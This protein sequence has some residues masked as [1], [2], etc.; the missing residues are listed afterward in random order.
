V[1]DERLRGT[2]ILGVLRDG[3]CALAGDGQVTLGSTVPSDLIPE[4]QGRFP[5]RVELDPLGRDELRRILVEPESSLIRQYTALMETEGVALEFTGGALD[6]IAAIA[7]DVNERAENI[8]ARRL[9]TVMERLMEEIAFSSPSWRGARVLVDETMV[10][11]RLSDVVAD[12]DLA[13]FIL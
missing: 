13:R 11:E 4:L 5:V 9:Q 2:T 3:R 10:E 1:S 7:A 8:G 12:L 6:R